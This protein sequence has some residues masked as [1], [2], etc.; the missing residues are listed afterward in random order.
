MHL[1]R[2]IRELGHVPASAVMEMVGIAL[3]SV[4]VMS[5]YDYLIRRHFRFRVG[6][7]N[8][9]RYAWIANTFNNLIGFAGLA[10]VASAHC[11]IRKAVC[12]LL[13]LRPH[14]YFFR[15]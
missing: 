14:S 3:L 8:T 6:I 1:G 10:G 2:T 7:W 12:P 15:R 5:A 9:F 4:A 13:P 11:F